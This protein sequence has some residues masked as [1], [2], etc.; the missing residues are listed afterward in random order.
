MTEELITEKFSVRGLD[1]A[2]CGVKIEREL[3]RLDSVE[4]AVLDFARLTL[5]V[6]TNSASRIQDAVRQIDPQVQ[7]S[8]KSEI[9]PRE[10]FS[11][12]AV[13]TTIK[14]NEMWLILAGMLFVFQLI[15]EEWL[16][17]NSLGVLEV[18]VVAA[19][20]LLAGWNVL[21]GGCQNNEKRKLFR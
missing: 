15:A 1:C 19:A 10:D 4:T 11:E 9:R 6:K 8:Q 2:A 20:Y 16:H 14:R 18:M 21:G 5:H 7:L 12:P 17:R 3:N 13:S